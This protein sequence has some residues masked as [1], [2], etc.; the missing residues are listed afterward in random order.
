MQLQTNISCGQPGQTV[1]ADLESRN[2]G[3]FSKFSAYNILSHKFLNTQ[4]N[5]TSSKKTH[6]TNCFSCTKNLGHTK[7]CKVRLIFCVKPACSYIVA[8]MSLCVL[9]CVLLSIWICWDHNF[10]NHVWTSK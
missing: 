7:K 3:A 1:Q 5:G 9:A 8:I 10:F 4:R 6:K 2:V